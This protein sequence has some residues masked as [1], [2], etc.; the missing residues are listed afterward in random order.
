LYKIIKFNICYTLYRGLKAGTPPPPPP[1]ASVA[2]AAANSSNLDLPLK[3]LQYYTVNTFLNNFF[4]QR[5]TSGGLYFLHSGL[6]KG[7]PAF[8]LKIPFWIN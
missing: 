3:T 7:N 2:T 6:G 8:S 4:S 1:L 5:A